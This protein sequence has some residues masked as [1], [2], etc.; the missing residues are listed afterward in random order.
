MAGWFPGAYVASTYSI[1]FAALW[2]Q[3]YRGVLFD[4]DNTLVPHGAPADERAIEFFAHLHTLGFQVYLL[5]NNKEPRVASFCQQVERAR[6]IYK[7]AKPKPDAYLRAVDSMN[8]SPSQVLFVGDQIFTDIWGA[9][10]AGIHSILTRPLLPFKE[11]PQIILKRFL[12]LPVL[13][14]YLLIER[15]KGND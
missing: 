10:L 12:E 14:L 3:G 15:C 1:D 13:G 2:G 6:Y 8:L 7:A 11:E 9:N 4:V 5:S